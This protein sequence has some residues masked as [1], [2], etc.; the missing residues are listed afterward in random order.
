MYS[1][2]Y[3][4]NDDRSEWGRKAIA[5][6]VDF[7]RFHPGDRDLNN[8]KILIEAGR[9]LVS[10]IFHTLAEADV[11]IEDFA[12]SCIESWTEDIREE[13]SGL[14]G[15]VATETRVRVL[16]PG[17]T[18]STLFPQ[19]RPEAWW[20]LFAD[21]PSMRFEPWPIGAKRHIIAGLVKAEAEAMQD[22]LA[23][24]ADCRP[25]PEWNP[26]VA[27]VAAEPDQENSWP[28]ELLRTLFESA[29][30]TAFEG[31]EAVEAAAVETHLSD[32]VAA[33]GRKGY[34]L[35]FELHAEPGR[36]LVNVHHSSDRPVICV[37]TGR[38][39]PWQWEDGQVRLRQPLSD[40][41]ADFLV[42]LTDA[43]A[44]LSLVD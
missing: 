13:T 32:L 19:S 25:V 6:L 30:R 23:Q 29:H 18:G 4:T 16:L 34:E 43:V 12:A 15:D 2:D 35:V 11:D 39:V 5:W 38:A 36:D 27:L 3:P 14:V 1:N 37:S 22:A 26:E 10:Y 17:A 28:P 44:H 31:Y 20:E 41:D 21:E 8:R 9:D 40:A 33:A 24:A 42:R 7:T